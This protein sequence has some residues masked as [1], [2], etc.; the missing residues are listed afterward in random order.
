M[1]SF[2]RGNT[3]NMIGRTGSVGTTA[4]ALVEV[5]GFKAGEGVTIKNI[6]STEDLLVGSI[7]NPPTT[8]SGYTLQ[9]GE[10]HLFKVQDTYNI[11]VIASANTTDYTWIQY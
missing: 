6:D 1:S 3:A 4:A 8:T 9:P 10:E 2:A 11:L 5:P 7:A